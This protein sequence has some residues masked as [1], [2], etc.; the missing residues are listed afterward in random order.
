MQA[1]AD[2]AL[3]IYGRID[4]LV[5]NAGLMLFSYRTS[6]HTCSDWRG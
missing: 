2:F 6:V 5:N 3:A 1:L 4:I